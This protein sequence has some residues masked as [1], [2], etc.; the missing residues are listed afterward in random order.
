MS[1]GIPT[2]SSSLSSFMPPHS[3]MRWNWWWWCWRCWW[4]LG[5]NG[6]CWHL[7]LRRHQTT[8]MKK[9][10]CHEWIQNHYSWWHVW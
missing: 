7:S 1:L 9:H 4:W 5:H 6:R 8:G 10:G 3:R 2:S